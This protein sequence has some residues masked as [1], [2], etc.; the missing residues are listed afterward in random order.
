MQVLA[1][2]NKFKKIDLKKAKDIGPILDIVGNSI[3]I[4]FAAYVIAA[5][6]TSVMIPFIGG[7]PKKR[8][9]TNVTFEHPRIEKATNYR[10][11]RN[12]VLARNIFNSEGILPE[13]ADPSEGV[14]NA[15]DPNG[16]CQKPTVNVELMGIIS[17]GNAETSLATIQEKGYTIADVYKA[18]EKII[19]QEQ[20]LIYSIEE[21][22]VIL[23]NNGVKECLE[24]NTVKV[25]ANAAT[26]APAKAGNTPDVAASTDPAEQCPPSGSTSLESSYVED[27]L[28][29]GFSKILE[30]GRL[31]P[32]HRENAMVGFKLIGVR[33]GS[34]W[35]RANLGSGDV[36]TAV[37]GQS[38][39]QPEKGFALYEALQA[40]KAIRVEFLKAG[41]TP[42]ILNVEIK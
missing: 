13:E 32:F 34:L 2:K 20:A 39:A 19:N 31:V 7:T 41:K 30:A 14:A 27:A 42:C 28:G 26:G 24:L 36:I 22:K 5:I 9:A 33:G 16:I 17:T 35:A 11:F 18:G 6:I 37:N 29:P 8:L 3:V 23:N 4:I 38:M 25:L 15:F 1:L 21:D 12:A 10:D 40:D